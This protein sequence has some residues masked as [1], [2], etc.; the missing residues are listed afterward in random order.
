MLVHN[1]RKLPPLRRVTAYVPQYDSE[2]LASA[3]RAQGWTVSRYLAW[4]ITES[5]ANEEWQMRRDEEE[6][7]AGEGLL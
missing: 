1:R 6:V 3:A 5:R 2:W 7:L 4:L